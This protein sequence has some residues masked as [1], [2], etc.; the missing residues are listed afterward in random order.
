MEK[1]IYVFAKKDNSEILFFDNKS[2]SD[3]FKLTYNKDDEYEVK[4][5]N[6]SHL[7]DIDGKLKKPICFMR[8]IALDGWFNELTLTTKENFY[9]NTISNI[10]NNFDSVKY[11]YSDTFKYESSFNDLFKIITCKF[12]RSGSRKISGMY[13]ELFYDINF[14][15]INS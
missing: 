4:E 15:L 3:R 8:E 2:D 13:F 11:S 5:F 9:I 12:Y 10:K 7:Y 14:N 6:V 1:S